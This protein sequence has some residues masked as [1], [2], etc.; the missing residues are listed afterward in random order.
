[1]ALDCS[2]A[3]KSQVWKQKVS[4]GGGLGGGAEAGGQT[5]MQTGK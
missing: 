4:S 2:V 5:D 1:M 3:N